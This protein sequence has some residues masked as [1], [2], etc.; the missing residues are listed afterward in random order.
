V[1]WKVEEGL[2]RGREKK[3]GSLKWSGETK[4]MK[5]V[6]VASSFLRDLRSYPIDSI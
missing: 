1:P 3:R 2:G 4:G 6:I 5:D